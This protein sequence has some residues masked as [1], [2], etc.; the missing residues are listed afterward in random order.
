MQLHVAEDKKLVAKVLAK[1]RDAFDQFF[2]LYFPKLM[3]FCARRVD[4]ADAVEDIVQETLIK[5]V[6]SLHTYRGEALLFSW[7]CMICRH[8]IASWYKRHGRVQHKHISLDDDPQVLAALESL[9]LEMHG[10]LSEE[11][12]ITDLVQLTLDYLPDKYAKVLRLKYLQ[13]LSVKEIAQELGIG[14]LAVQSV[15]ARART[16]FRKGIRELSYEQQ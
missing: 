4:D 11:L 8:E 14:K 3:R 6:R 2:A 16:A 9:S 5:A 13:G 12:A 1:D 7:L 15:L 10:S